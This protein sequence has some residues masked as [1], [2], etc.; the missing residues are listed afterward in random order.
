MFASRFPQKRIEVTYHV[1]AEV[2]TSVLLI[3]S[4]VGLIL[5]YQWARILSPLSLGMLLY[6]EL[7][8][9]G[10]YASQRDTQMVAV[11]YVIAF[12]TVAAIIG[13]LFFG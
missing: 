8:G 9:P 11:F 2:V 6:A 13:F 10:F 3:A 5:D 7:N 12:L 1:V 4:G